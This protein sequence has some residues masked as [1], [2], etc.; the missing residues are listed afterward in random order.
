MAPWADQP[1]ALIPIKGQKSKTPEI[2]FIASEMANAHNNL[3]RSLNSVYNQAPYVEK[4]EDQR[5]LLLYTGFWVD[6]IEGEMPSAILLH[7]SSFASPFMMTPLSLTTAKATRA[8]MRLQFRPPP[9]RGG[10]LLPSGG[11]H[12]R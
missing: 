1:F 4:K 2:A 9:R 5:D 3:L 7:T 6:W 10:T 12:H 11:T 8:D